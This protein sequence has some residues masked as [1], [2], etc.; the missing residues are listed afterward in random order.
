MAIIRLENVSKT[1]LA[2][3]VNVPA[4]KDI[5]LSVQQ[6]ELVALMGASGSGKT[7]SSFITGLAQ[8][9]VAQAF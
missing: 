8:L 1:Y 9:I 4:L 6:G 3:A 7:R 2:G 5:S